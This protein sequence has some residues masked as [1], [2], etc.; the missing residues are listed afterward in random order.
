M[1]QPTGGEWRVVPAGHG[2][3]R[4]GKGLA[5]QTTL[6]DG[7]EPYLAY[8]TLPSESGDDGTADPQ[9]DGELMAKAPKLNRSLGLA[10]NILHRVYQ[11]AGD[12]G[13]SNDLS[14]EIEKFLDDHISEV[15]G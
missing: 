12:S 7:R 10:L 6:E 1:K 5:I 9:V 2:I 14:R 11:A 4:T 8:L 3:F 13:L 15:F